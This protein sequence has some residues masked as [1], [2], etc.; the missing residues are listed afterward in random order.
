MLMV[1]MILHD[2]DKLQDLLDAWEAI[3]VPGATILHSTGLGRTRTNPGMW[4]DLPLIPNLRDFYEHDEYFGRTVFTVVPDEAMADK[5]VEATNQVTGDL[6]QP[7]TGMLVVL[8]LL[9]V[10]GLVKREYK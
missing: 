6:D 3:G 8:P 7:D 10:F 9:K 5:V 2:P 1:M 4:D